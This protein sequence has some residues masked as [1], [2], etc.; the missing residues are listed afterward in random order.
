MTEASASCPPRVP[1][2]GIELDA[3]T[4]EHAASRVL[5]LVRDEA[6]HCR[7]V[8]TPNLDHVVLLRN[9]ERLR[10]AYADA[11]MVVA[12]GWPVVLASRLFGRPLPE[13]V[14]GV[15]LVTTVFETASPRLPVF[16]LGALPGVAERAAREIPRRWPAVE[17][18]GTCSPPPG[19]EESLEIC[20]AIVDEIR[21]AEPRI[22]VVGLGCPKQEMWVYAHRMRLGA[23]V[24][25]C[26]GATIDFLAGNKRRA[27]VWLRKHGLEWLHRLATEPLRLGPRYARCAWMFPRLLWEEWRARH[28]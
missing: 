15:D 6:A 3:V 23:C 27:P 10:A 13:R 21:R 7:Y 12:D 2:F 11:T 17:I 5:T 19:F 16:L 14:T 28:A 4:L 25:I 18:V 26:A 20:D 24:A 9:H 1:L 8:V 22:L